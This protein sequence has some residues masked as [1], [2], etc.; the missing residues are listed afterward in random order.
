MPVDSRDEHLGYG[1]DE[2]RRIAGNMWRMTRVE[3]DTFE[4]EKL[5]E[6]LESVMR[7]ARDAAE[8]TEASHGAT[9][10]FH[11]QIIDYKDDRSSKWCYFIQGEGHELFC[12]LEDGEIGWS[13]HIIDAVIFDT[14]EKAKAKIEELGLIFCGVASRSGPPQPFLYTNPY[15]QPKEERIRLHSESHNDYARR[16]GLLYP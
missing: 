13:R 4:G 2:F 9:K 5:D 8:S 14:E 3:A 7:L 16:L 11:Q 12:L 10:A 15:L 6:Y 1:D